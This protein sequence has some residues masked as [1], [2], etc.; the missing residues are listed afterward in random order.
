M[1][2]F[3]YIGDHETTK[4]FGLSFVRGEATDVADERAI[5]KLRANRDFNES[6]DGVEVLDAIEQPQERTKRKYTRRTE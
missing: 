5:Q 4:V 3:V 6:F 1:A 2:Q